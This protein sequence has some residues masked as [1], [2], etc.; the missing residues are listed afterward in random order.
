M[1]E[2]RLQRGRGGQSCRH[3]GSLTDP[4]E[5]QRGEGRS[6]VRYKTQSRDGPGTSF[7]HDHWQMRYIGADGPVS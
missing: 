5:R 3:S 4:I 6:T 1:C 2:A 7:D